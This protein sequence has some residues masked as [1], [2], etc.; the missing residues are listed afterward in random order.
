M[1]PKNQSD[2]LRQAAALQAAIFNS[3]MFSKIATDANGVIQIFNVGAERML[4]YTAAEVIDRITPADI[5]DPAELIARA[6]ALSIEL[7]TPIAPGFDALVFKAAHGIEDIYEL[8]CIRKNG[9]RF[10]VVV[11]VTALRDADEAIIGY[12]LIATDNSARKQAEAAKR[13]HDALLQTIHL[14]SI[15]SVT[16]RSGRIVEVNDGFCLI[17]GY[18]RAELLGQT[19]RIVNSGVQSETFW[20]DMWHHRG[21]TLA[22]RDLQSCEGRIALLGRQRHRPF[23]RRSGTDPEVHLHPHRCHRSHGSCASPAAHECRPGACQA[24][25]REGEPGEV[26]VSVEHEPRV[27]LAAERDS[28]L[29][30]AAG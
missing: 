4:G 18:S 20:I 11:S 23:P 29:R 25:C 30:A 28:R 15:V 26:G 24:S 6:K 17:S 19:H 16:D 5:S 14:H 3:A 12:L 1:P 7:S 8:T 22:R 10:P 21:R 2:A 27:A 9:S 13:E